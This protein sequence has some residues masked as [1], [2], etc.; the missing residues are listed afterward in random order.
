MCDRGDDDPLVQTANTLADIQA[1][2]AH[3]RG[4]SE[5]G[6]FIKCVTARTIGTW[7]EKISA[8]LARFPEGVVSDDQSSC[9]AEEALWHAALE[10][11]DMTTLVRL[12]W[13]LEDRIRRG[14]NEA[15]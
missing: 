8:L 9:A 4:R 14:S 7:K 15:G 2:V 6:L 1:F 12:L 5:T 11:R 10:D 3:C 13:Q